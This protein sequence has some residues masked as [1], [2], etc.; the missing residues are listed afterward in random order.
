MKNIVSISG[1]N[2]PNNYTS[3]ALNIVN[4]ELSKKGLNPMV[5]DARE[6]S[7]SFPGHP[8]SDA[9][10]KLRAGIEK[11]TGVVL[12]TPEYHG[13][14]SAMTKLIIE[15]L[16]FPSVLAGKPV[17]LIGVAAGRIGAIKSLEQLKGVCSHIGAI[18]VP[19]SVSIAGVQSIFE[20][21]G[22]CTDPGSEKALRGVAQSLLDFIKDYVCPKYALEEMVRGEA[23]PWSAKI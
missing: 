18:V 3:R 14:F 15:N 8:P 5:F 11:A 13:S 21:N 17:A 20:D 2:R 9:T 1:T 7:L 6:L 16:G 23:Q 12:A 4:D 22:H 10:E 19:G